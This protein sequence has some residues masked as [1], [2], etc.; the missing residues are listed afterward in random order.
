VL[1]KLPLYTY[2]MDKHSS[3]FDRVLILPVLHIVPRFLRGSSVCINT[4]DAFTV[5]SPLQKLIADLSAFGSLFTS[6]HPPQTI[7]H[8]YD[9]IVILVGLLFC[10][11][12]LCYRTHRTIELVLTNWLH[13]QNISVYRQAMG[14]AD[15]KHEVWCRH[16]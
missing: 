10:Y 15:L 12:G 3:L 16:T 5:H 4:F 11:R 6:S 7:Y 1:R 13:Y 9:L 8:T 2:H 14:C